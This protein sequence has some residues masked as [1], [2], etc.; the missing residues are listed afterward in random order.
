M[1]ALRTQVDLV[2]KLVEKKAWPMPTYEDLLF[3]L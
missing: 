1:N 3:T 2:E